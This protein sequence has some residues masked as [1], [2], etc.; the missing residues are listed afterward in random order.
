[1]V[2]QA[3]AKELK[4]T[5][6]DSLID[7]PPILAAAAS[8][9]PWLFRLWTS[10]NAVWMRLS[11]EKQVGAA[12]LHHVHQRYQKHQVLLNRLSAVETSGDHSWMVS[13][14]RA[15]SDLM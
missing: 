1:M 11:V 14:D 4:L 5:S 9:S 12:P 8:L 13:I 2:P 7:L 10:E 6:S 15:G 3:L